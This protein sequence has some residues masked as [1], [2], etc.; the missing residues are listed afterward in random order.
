MHV[1]DFIFQG[2]ALEAVA[3]K[4]IDDHSHYIS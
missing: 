2:H 3:A 1:I 4:Y